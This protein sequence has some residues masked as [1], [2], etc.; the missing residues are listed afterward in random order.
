MAWSVHEHQAN[1]NQ[2]TEWSSGS[3]RQIVTQQKKRDA[4]YSKTESLFLYLN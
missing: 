1:H 4:L 2:S 3:A